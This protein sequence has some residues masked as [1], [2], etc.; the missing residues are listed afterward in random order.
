MSEGKESIFREY[1]NDV[2][3][4]MLRLEKEGGKSHT[5]KHISPV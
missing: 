4:L 3:I 2:I 5:S 1:Y